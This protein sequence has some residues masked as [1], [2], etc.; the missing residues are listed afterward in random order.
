MPT[1][2]RR[3]LSGIASMRNLMRKFFASAFGLSATLALVAGLVFAW[4]GTASGPA[5]PSYMGNVTAYLSID[6][7]TGNVL[8]PNVNA[9]TASGS[10]YNNTGIPIALTGGSIT[11]INVPGNS[12]CNGYITGSVGI[13]VAGPVA[14]ATYG[15]GWESFLLLANNTH[16]DCQGLGV[17][18]TI[19]VNVT[20]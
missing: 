19:N 18:Y 9:K 20:T 3:V 16:Q 14:H 5:S 8:L 13:T 7:Y 17:D 6:S 2:A 4:T 1:A 11:G 12:G 10:V 15:G